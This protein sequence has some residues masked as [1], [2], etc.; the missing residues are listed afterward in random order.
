MKLVTVVEVQGKVPVTVLQLHNRVN[1]GNAV[2]LEQA[3]R[4][5]FYAGGRNMV[6][7]LSGAAS[8]TSAGIRSILFI[9]KMLS[10]GGTDK[11]SHLKL[12]SPT[13]YV[14]DVLSIA[15]LLVYIE[16]FTSLDEAVASF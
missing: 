11:A 5:A 8:L 6:L 9:Q 14:K 13:P 10:G 7:D 15:G 3:A 1:L 16:V 4:Q 12:V 2:E